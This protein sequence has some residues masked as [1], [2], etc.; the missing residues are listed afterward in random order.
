MKRRGEKVFAEVGDGVL[1]MK[2]I[3][4][5]GLEMGAEYFTVEQDRT[6]KPELES[7]EISFQNLKAIAQELNI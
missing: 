6:D 5:R 2:A 1:D 7:A 4:T 3:I